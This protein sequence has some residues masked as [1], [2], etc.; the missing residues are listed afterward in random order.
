MDAKFGSLFESIGNFFTGGEQIPWCDRDV[1]AVTRIHFPFLSPINLKSKL[2]FLFFFI[3]AFNYLFLYFK[4]LVFAFRNS[5]MLDWWFFWILI[6]FSWTSTLLRL[7]SIGG[8]LCVCVCVNSWLICFT[9][10]SNWMLSMDFF[11][12][13]IFLNWSWIWSLFSGLFNLW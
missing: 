5:N 11:A 8:S 3:F 2:S 9:L 10:I 7:E 12:L 4:T 1:I 13:D 6:C